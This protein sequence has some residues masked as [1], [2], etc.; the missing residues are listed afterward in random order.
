MRTTLRLVAMGLGLALAAVG[1]PAHAKQFTTFETGQV[2]PLALS[3]DGTKLFALNTPDSRLEIFTVAP[4]GLTHVVSVPVGLEP[5]AVAARSNTEVWVVN[6]LSDSVSIVDAGATPPHV[7]RT[8]LV[9]D[10]P[11]DI[12]FGGSAHDR[13]FITTAHRGQNRP[14]FDPQLTTPGIGRADVFVFDVNNLGGTLEGTPLTVVTLFTDTPRALAVSADGS[15]VYAAGFETGNQTTAVNEGV[16]CDT[17]QT[18][19]TNN[20]VQGSCSISGSTYPGGLPLPHRSSD[21][22]V[23]PETGLVVKYN[24]GAGQWRDQLGRNWN[25]A[26][27]FNLPD[28]DV[29]AINANATPPVQTAFFTGVGTVLFNMAVNPV[30]GK[31]YVSN[32]EARNEVRFEGP[33]GGG[34]TVQGHLHEA[35]ITVL[36]GVTV[37]PRHLNKHINY[38]LRPA[39]AGVK[40]DSLAIPTQMAVSSSGSTLYVAAFGS[41]KIGIFDTTTL[42]NDTFTPSSTNHILLSGGGPS[43]LVLDEANGKLYVLTRFDNSI[44]VVD[45]ASKTEE[46]HLSL[47][48]P[49][50]PS[51]VTGRPFLYDAY[52]TS[53]NG[54]ASCASCHIFGDF[55]SLAW[56]LGNPDDV[57][58]HN[59]NPIRVENVINDF[60]PGFF[61]SSKDFHPIKGPMTTQSLRGMAN[62]GPMHWRGDRTGG[63]DPGGDPLDEDAAFKK[64]NVA[65][66]GLVG[67]TGPL[68][69]DEMQE[70]TDFV[71]QVTYPPN[72]IHNLDNSLT[73]QQQAGRTH[74]HAPQNVDVFENCDGC[75]RHDPGQRHFG[76]DGFSSFEAEPQFFKIAHLRNLYQKVGMFGM[77]AVQFF[78]NSGDNGA[79]GDQVRGF[80]FLHDGSVDTVFRFLQAQAF[81]QDQPALGGILGPNPNPGGFPSGAAG[82]LQRRDM[83]AFVLAMDSEEAPIVGQQVTLTASNGATVGG[84]ID[85]LTGRAAAHECDLVVTGTIAGVARGWSFD[86]LMFHGDLSTDAPLSDAALRA[87]AAT[88]GQELTYTCVPPGSGIRMA[89]DHDGDGV[90]DGDEV[91]RGTDPLDPIPSCD[92][93]TLDRARIRLSRNDGL[94]GDERLTV[95]GQTVIPGAINPIAD[96]MSFRIDDASGATLFI[97]NVPG[98]AAPDAQSPGWVHDRTKWTYRNPVGTPDGV[99]KVS[100]TDR[101]AR[102]P[103]LFKVSIAATSNF[104]TAAAD[105]PLRVM[106]RIGA[107]AS[108]C[109]E[110]RYNAATQPR[111]R[112]KV[113]RGNARVTCS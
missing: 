11:R 105:V 104:Q 77:P 76:T 113:S 44:S 91:L 25:N 110:A 46:G 106:V 26:V 86:G 100:I 10:E 29:F 27:K 8:L 40:D 35:R 33:G 47:Y 9:G 62:N 92:G 107:G 66:A 98:G 55:D 21:Q 89:I 54:E 108:Q 97:R 37:T 36:D 56:D 79:K 13:A 22:V 68:T 2:R 45:V 101:T 48:N 82:D 57:V 111:P 7:V 58:M 59:P 70:F 5:I 28:K 64:F 95:K 96:G 1:S 103:G 112:C 94:P 60:F 69:D 39:P 4:E 65:F 19:I 24:Q 12:V 30:S 72:P 87:F 18:N 42:E 81:N 14:G 20:T 67:R 73:S 34:S 102:Q 74:F 41:S 3:P 23:R 75:H 80:G 83:E 88:A 32:T 17:S 61:V 31:V 53:S 16:V 15:T 50:P 51:V 85:L 93:G 6:H 78:F 109:G 43:G 84:R 99:T 90:L 38:A 63:N 71:L 49:E 52:F